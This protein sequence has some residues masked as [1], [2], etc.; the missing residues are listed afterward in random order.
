M[1][2]VTPLVSI[3]IC[4]AWDVA[5]WSF[6]HQPA[7]LVAS[8]YIDVI[9]Q[10]SGLAIVLPPQKIDRE[11]AGALIDRVDG[12][13]LIGGSD[14]EPARYGEPPTSRLEATAPL[15][16]E[17]ELTLVRTALDRDLPVLG[18]CRGLQVLNTATGGTLHQDL[19]AAG[20]GEHRP[21]PG[22][23]DTPSMH[24][25]EVMPRTRLSGA[26]D[27]TVW[28]VNSHHHQGVAEV[29]KGGVVVARSIPDGA[30]EAIEWPEYRHALGVQWH[31]EAL[32]EDTTVRALIDAARSKA[33]RFETGN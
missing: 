26:D 6:W 27:A 7:A 16:D 1:S 32:E 5:A 24:A 31:P 18:I 29:G 11:E 23:L 8:S 15:R 30:I 9:R 12:L 4:A 19:A 25:I 20:F 14:V 28:V 2:A 10:A 3:G 17:F 22:R 33:S 13:I 21:A